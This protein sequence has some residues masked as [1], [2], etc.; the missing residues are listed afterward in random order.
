MLEK[1]E[2]LK[3]KTMLRTCCICYEECPE[4][5][6][7]TLACGHCA[8]TECLRDYFKT[9]VA[10][11]LIE[12]VICPEFICKKPLAKE[13]IERIMGDQGFKKYVRATNRLKVMQS[14]GKWK[15]CPLP[16]CEGILDLTRLRSKF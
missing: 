16:N 11:N 10:N 12:K 7:T 15:Y 5:E 1:P 9:M 8:M 2:D 4:E 3:E 13:E 14:K 6:F